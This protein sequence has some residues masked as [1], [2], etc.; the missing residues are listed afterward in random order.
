MI[1]NQP[2]Q[3]RPKLARA[4]RRVKV[5]MAMMGIASATWTFSACSGS[6]VDVAAALAVEDVTTGWFDA[7]FDDYGRN[8][9]VPTIS[10]RLENTSADDVGSV[11]LNAIFRRCLVAYAGQ[12]EPVSEVSPEMRKQARARGRCRSGGA[13]TLGSLAETV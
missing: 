8:K 5:M 9:L 12:P 11:Q 1:Y 10:L 3:S 4:T 7:G 13:R 6:A 2:M